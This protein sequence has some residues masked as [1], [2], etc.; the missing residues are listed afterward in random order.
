[1][2]ILLIGFPHSIHT[3]NWIKSIDNEENEIHFFPSQSF[4]AINQNFPNVIFHSD[5]NQIDWESIKITNVVHKSI[6]SGIGKMTS[7]NKLLRK[8]LRNLYKIFGI[9][10]AHHS[11]LAKVIQNEKPDVVHLLETQNSGYLYLDALD[12]LPKH[13]LYLSVW[14]IDLHYFGNLPDHK[15][16]IEELLS[17]VDCLFVEGTRDESIAKELG[18][19][20]STQIIQATGGLNM[21]LIDNVKATS[22]L[23]SERKAI[24]IKGTQNLVRRGL[25]AISAIRPIAEE[26]KGWKIYVYSYTEDVHDECLKLMQE[27]DLDIELMSAVSNEE[28]LRI[29]AKCRISMIINRSDGI[30]NSLLE[31]MSVGC[32]PIISNTSC[33]DDIIVHDEN[34][35][36]VG[37]DNT[38]D[39]TEHLLR[40]INDDKLVNLS[41]DMNYEII[42]NNFDRVMLKEKIKLIYK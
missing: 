27:Y 28:L 35:F 42:Q 34:G 29:Y 8:I 11:F 15:P 14:G 22:I 1:M 25:F 24:C 4:Q 5:Y 7:T 33:A 2:K 10:D 26:L 19:Q 17:K 37:H 41:S 20:N 32:F 30:S 38:Q 13:K 21:D 31:S 3:V 9:D 12:A 6:T 40:A 18:Y 39:I 36:I 16:K 23:T